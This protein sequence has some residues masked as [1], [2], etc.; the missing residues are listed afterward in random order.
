MFASIVPLTGTR[1]F[2]MFILSFS[3][4]HLTLLTPCITLCLIPPCLNPLSV[5]TL[6]QACP[7]AGVC[8]PACKGIV[9]F[10]YQFYHSPP[11]SLQFAYVFSVHISADGPLYL[12]MYKLYCTRCRQRW[13]GNDKGKMEGLPREGR[14]KGFGWFSLQKGRPHRLKKIIKAKEV[15]HKWPWVWLRQKLW[16][17]PLR[18]SDFRA[19]RQ[20]KKR[21]T[22]VWGICKVCPMIAL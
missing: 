2:L 16:C 21:C 19:D 11:K 9:G 8:S 17:S 3:S 1:I 14:R 18:K 10:V 22:E 6:S 15:Q 5:F 7:Q 4:P 20:T 13:A 12:R